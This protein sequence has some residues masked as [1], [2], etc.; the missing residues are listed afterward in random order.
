MG[1]CTSSAVA[2][3]NEDSPRVADPKFVMVDACDDGAASVDKLTI[4]AL[5]VSGSRLGDQQPPS[6]TGDTETS[7]AREM[8]V[9][10]SSSADLP[11]A[12]EADS[13]ATALANA[14][15]RVQAVQRGRA[16]RAAPP[17]APPPM[18]VMRSQKIKKRPPLM[19]SK[20]RTP[21]HD[22]ATPPNLNFHFRK[23]A[24]EDVADGD[25]ESTCSTKTC[26]DAA[27]ISEEAALIL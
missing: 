26:S 20:Y 1:A 2:A 21:R 6:Q 25:T 22:G 18:P 11:G 14:A 4:K 16:A 9:A 23:E 24:R 10:G 8:A 13:S 5:P 19:P 27:P 17:D 15:I 3:S 12:A 7:T